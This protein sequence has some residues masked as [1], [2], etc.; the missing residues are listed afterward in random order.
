MTWFEKLTGFRE[1]S[2]D[3]VR[4]KLVIEGDCIVSKNGK[5]LAFGFLETPSLHELRQRIAKQASGTGR[6]KLAERVADV[7][8]LHADPSHA[9]ALFQVASQFNLLE[10]TGPSVTPERGVGIYENDPTQGPA[11]AIAC[12]AGTIYRN[13]FA[14]V[15]GGVGQTAERQIDCSSELGVRLG[16]QEGSLW[17]MQNG[18]LFPTDAG[19]K[20]ITQ[21]LESANEAERDHFRESLRIG[22]Q[23][24]VD[25]TLAGANHRV[26]QAYCSALPVAYGSQPT[27]AWTPFARMILEASYEATLCAAILNQQTYGSNRLFL[28]LLGGGVFGN[29]ETWIV[30]A[31]ERAVNRYRDYDLCVEIVSY[32]AS[33][34]FV[35]DL[36]Q[37]LA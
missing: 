29:R 8:Q 33:N 22:L 14:V 18:Y 5:R 6:V 4:S 25:V 12:G 28:T 36:V 34:R 19:L 3:E 30:D 26:S 32:R 15:D 2:A 31:I 16:N 7:R 1:S 35:N 13:Y 23:W 37:R 17:K 20:K 9:N 10:M 27:E 11:C 21:Q 24:N